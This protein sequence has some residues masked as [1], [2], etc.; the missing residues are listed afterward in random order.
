MG[1][2]AEQIAC[3]ALREWLLLKLPAKVTSVNTDRAAVL[4]APRAGPYT[5]PA[6]ASLKLGTVIGSEAADAITA[7]TRSTAQV[8]ADLSTAGITAT[9]DTDDRLV[10]TSTTAPTSGVPSTVALGADTTGANAAFG[11]DPGGERVVRSALVAP[12]SKGVADGW[13]I[14]PDLGPGFWII[15]GDRSSQELGVHRDEY[16]V[17][18]DLAILRADPNTSQHRSREHIHAC[19]R[20]VREVLLSDAGR[21]LGRA[22][23]GDIMFV[24]ESGCRIAGKPFAFQSDKGVSPLMDVATLDLEIRVYERPSTT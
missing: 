14:T 22:S 17:A 13:P 7:G 16:L 3:Q 11:W 5:I 2:K 18:V 19:V 23:F 12:T 1:V 15:L 10:L 6:S 9:A 21:T 4:K 8:V 24:R 20:C